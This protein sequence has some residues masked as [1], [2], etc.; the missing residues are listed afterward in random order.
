MVNILNQQHL[1]LMIHINQ[2]P[3]LADSELVNILAGK[4]FQKM[5]WFVADAFKLVSD[6]SLKGRRCLFDEFSCLRV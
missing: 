4:M 6:A 2:S 3:V 1:A 5:K